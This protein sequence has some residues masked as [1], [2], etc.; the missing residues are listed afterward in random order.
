MAGMLLLPLV[1]LAIAW[2]QESLDQLVFGGRWALP[3]V[4][5]GPFWGC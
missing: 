5:G 2:L 1:L 3:M 4:H